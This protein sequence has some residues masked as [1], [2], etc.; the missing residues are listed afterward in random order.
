MLRSNLPHW[1]FCDWAP[2]WAYGRAPEGENAGS[3][4]LTLQLA[5]ALRNSSELMRH[6]GQECTAAEYDKIY[7]SLIEN[8]YEKCW[9]SERGLLKDYI[10]NA[11]YSQHANIMGILTDAIPAEDQQA[12]FEKLDSDTSISQATFYYRFYLFRALKKVGLADRYVDMLQPWHNMIGMG[13]TTFAENPEPAR[14]DCHAWSSSPNYDL[15]ATVCGVEPDAYGFTKVKIEPHMGRLNE[16]KGVVP[17]PKGNITVTLNRGGDKVK[18][19]VTLP[20]TLEG[21]F[22]WKGKELKLKPGTNNINL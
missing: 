2:E 4:V 13:L 21:R 7:R 1:N 17:H 20:A 11:S 10:G 18:G 3:A 19:T 12:V 5:D 15:L 22:V 16:I 14:S 6:F 9:D 8:T